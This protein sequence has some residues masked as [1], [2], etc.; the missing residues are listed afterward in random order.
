MKPGA[1][2]VNAARGGVLDE[3]A[4]AEA[5]R[6]GRLGGAALDVFE[7][8]PLTAAAGARFAG[9]ANLILTPH[10]AGLT[11]QSNIRVSEMIAARV[12]AHLEGPE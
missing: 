6:A 10:I 3:A 9:L 12:I 7:T 5:L 11:E 4:L 8:E 1:V 2:L